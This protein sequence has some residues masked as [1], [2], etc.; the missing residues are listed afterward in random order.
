MKRILLY[1][2]ICLFMIF[3]ALPISSAISIHVGE[4]YSCNIGGISNFKECVWTTSD[5]QCMDFVGSV[6]RYST[7]VI[8]KALAKPS[9]ASP[10]TIHCQYYYYD[11]DPTTGR[12]TY[13]RSGYK[14]FQFFI[15]EAET[16]TPQSVSVS[17]TSLTLNVGESRLLSA[18]IYPSSANQSVEWSTEN[19]SIASVSSSGYVTARGPGDTYIMAKTINGKTALCHVYV[20]SSSSAEVSINSTN[21]PDENFRNF[22]L[23]QTY[24]QDN[25]ITV[26]EFK[27]ITTLAITA[28]SIG[29]LK[30]IEYFTELKSL[31]CEFNRLIALD[32]SRN[33]NLTLLSCDGN[34]LTALDVS[35]NV[36]LT[37]LSCSNNQLTTLDL[38]KNTTLEEL[39]CNN[40]QLTAIDVSK[41]NVLRWL[42]CECNNLT[43]LDIKNSPTLNY[44]ACN[45]NQ[46]STLDLSKNTKLGRLY[47]HHNIIRDVGMDAL[48]NSLPPKA[49]SFLFVIDNTKDGEGNV[50]TKTQVLAAKAKGWWTQEY[51]GSNWVAYE[52]SDD[53][54]PGDIN[55]DG[56]VDV[57][58]YIGIANNIMGNT[59]NGFNER[60]AD[61]DNNGI[62]DVSDYVGVANLIITG[63]IYGGS[64]TTP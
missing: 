35:N 41:N 36:A 8:V 19:A 43:T 54:I 18:S 53:N 42:C 9:Y 49:G 1:Y 29:S 23:S 55:G 6:S 48:I 15:K 58:D 3:F 63:N 34:Q 44:M 31:Y 60:A 20:Q 4:T 26:D 5:Y 64:Q 32:V 7:E 56:K 22:L 52:G 2:L 37:I 28:K 38:S 30:G 17:P 16:Q 11:L 14:D 46:L 24:G 50:C 57:S 33:T 62:I 25:V 10:V 61:V 13:L 39:N 59:P 12:Y 51:N 45:N 27:K 40:N 21:F 47:C